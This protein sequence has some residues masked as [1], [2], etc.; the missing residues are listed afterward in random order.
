[1]T[2]IVKNISKSLSWDAYCHFV[3][4]AHSIRSVDIAFNIDCTDFIEDFFIT[5]EE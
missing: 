5:C 3:L 1:M 4:S 2:I